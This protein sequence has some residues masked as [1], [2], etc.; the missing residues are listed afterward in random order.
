MAFTRYF[1]HLF[2]TAGPVG[3]AECIHV[4]SPRVTPDMNNLLLRAYTLEEIDLALSQMQP[5]KA[6]GP[7]GY[8]VCFYHKHWNTVG[9]EVRHAVLKFLNSGIFYP[10]INYTYLALIPKIF[11]ASSV[12][13]YHPISLCNVLYKIIA[14]VLANRLKQVLPSVIS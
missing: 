13:D 7:K 3:V 5:L 2:T 9:G 10:S 4:V 11:T 6:P 1:Q 8:R 14:K 12:C